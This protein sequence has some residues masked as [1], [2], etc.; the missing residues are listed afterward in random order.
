MHLD[1]TH[2]LNASAQQIY[3]MLMDHEVLARVTPGVKEL[4]PL[5]EGKYKALSDVKLG[6]V[7][8]SFKGQVEISDPVPAKSFTLNMK[9]SS[10]IGNVS[11]KG[12]ISLNQLSKNETE[13]IFSGDAKLSGTLARTGQRVMSG[14]AKTLTQQFF[15][16]LEAEIG[17]AQGMEV[18]RPGFFARLMQLLKNLF[19]R[20]QS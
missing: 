14:V 2:K 13:V 3:D 15:E 1:G 10:K 5:G 12:S 11:A 9:Q 17:E 6:P 20:S 7:N 19:G 18:K 8:G 16:A 4:Q